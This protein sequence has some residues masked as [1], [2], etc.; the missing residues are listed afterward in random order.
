MTASARNAIAGIDAIVAVSSA[1][2][3][4]GKSTVTVNL[5]VT[6]HRMGHRVG[7]LDAD[8]LGP[9]VAG[10]L[11]IEPMRTPQL[12]AAGKV[13]PPVGFGIKCISMALFGA[14]DQPMMLRGPMVGK[15]L[16]LFMSGV[17]WGELDFLLIDMPPGT[18]DV[19]LNIAQN[20]PLSGAIVVTTPQSVSVK[21][22][23]RGLRMLQSVQTPV[24]GVVE[25]MRTFACPQCGAVSDLFGRGGG[26][27]LA[28]EFGLAFL[29]AL[30]LDPAVIAA[31]DSGRP[32]PDGPATSATLAA[33]RALADR[34]IQALSGL[35][36]SMPPFRWQL[37]SDS[38]APPWNQAECRKGG[39]IDIPVGIRRSDARTLAILWQDGTAQEIDMRELRLACRCALCRDEMSGRPLADPARVPLDVRPLEIRS[40]GAYAISLSWSDGHSS[41]IYPFSAIRRMDDQ[42][43]AQDV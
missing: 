43:A 4:V 9:S 28:S 19:Q 30:P 16:N 25:N 32:V 14:E 3:G 15:Y 1:K 2:G 22:A 6:L 38:G 8:V 36:S 39:A 33:Y 41:G 29:G 17:D 20:F 5:A 35:D 27:L 24:L 34:M 12:T 37:D 23:R 40:V 10:M 26:E 31:G 42:S 11:G 7:I 13:D 21:I 18:G